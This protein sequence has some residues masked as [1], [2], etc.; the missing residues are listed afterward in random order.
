MDIII[1]IPKTEDYN[2]WLDECKATANNENSRINYCIGRSYLPKKTEPGEKCYVVYKGY[3][4]GYHIIDKLCWRNG[5]ICETTGRYWHE[6]NYIIRKG[7]Y[8]KIKPI[9]M[10]GFR[11]W[12]Y[13]KH[14]I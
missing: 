4:R 12:K 2:T 6:G 8:H 5:F 7:K 11:G 1:T 14:E 3:I 13:L 9:P 10:K